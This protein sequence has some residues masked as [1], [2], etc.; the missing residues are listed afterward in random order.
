[1]H[2]V[3]SRLEMSQVRNVKFNEDQY[4]P[5]RKNQTKKRKRKRNRISVSCQDY[6]PERTYLM[7]RTEWVENRNGKEKK[8]Y[9]K[10]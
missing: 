1:M 5:K 3:S 6:Q 4:K 9:L 8:T 2:G 7:E 10:K